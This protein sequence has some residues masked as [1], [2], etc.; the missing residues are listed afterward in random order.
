MWVLVIDRVR[1]RVMGSISISSINVCIF[2]IDFHVFHDL[3]NLI[4]I[5]PNIRIITTNSTP[6]LILIAPPI[7]VHSSTRTNVPQPLQHLQPLSRP[8]LPPPQ[9]RLLLHTLV[10]ARGSQGAASAL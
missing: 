1:I 9:P 5:I 3:E 6:T 7:L 2:P 4:H 10:P 8:R